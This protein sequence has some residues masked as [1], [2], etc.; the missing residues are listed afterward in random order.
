[1]PLSKDE[2]KKY[3]LLYL[4]TAKEYVNELNLNVE[5][6]RKAKLSR[7]VIETLHRAAH[8]LTSQSIMMSYPSMSEIASLLE[9]YFEE[10]KER[11]GTFSDEAITVLS[12]VVEHMDAC[13]EQIDRTDKEIDM[14]ADIKNLLRIAKNQ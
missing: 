5:S 7:T 1:M 4:Q 8:S 11:G 9:K 10:K 2:Q 3:K 12:A 6:L 14:T 13:L